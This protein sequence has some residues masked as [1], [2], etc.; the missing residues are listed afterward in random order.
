MADAWA[1]YVNQIVNKYDW[2]T[3]EVIHNGE[4]EEAA[5]FGQDGSGWYW[6]PGFPDIN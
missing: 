2:N 4:C 5:I 3:M 6:S 1:E